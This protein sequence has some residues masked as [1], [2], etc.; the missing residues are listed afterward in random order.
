MRNSSLWFLSVVQNTDLETEGIKFSAQEY[1]GDESLS[2]QKNSPYFL[3]YPSLVWFLANLGR[4]RL[5][6]L[7]GSGFCNRLGEVV[8]E[9]KIEG[10]NV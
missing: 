7:F 3:F 8:K 5:E 10:R 1:I 6:Y 2:R 9:Y 4:E